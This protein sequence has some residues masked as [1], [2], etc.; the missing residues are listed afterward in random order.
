[1]TLDAIRLAPEERDSLAVLVRHLYIVD[2]GAA[3][4]AALAGESRQTISLTR[5]CDEVDGTARRDGRQIVAV[6]GKREC[7]VG[8]REDE[9]AVADRVTIEHVLTHGHR[10]LGVTGTDGSDRHSHRL[11]STIARVHRRRHALGERLRLLR[12]RCGVMFA[13][14]CLRPVYSGGRF[15]AN[16]S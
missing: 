8:K 5:R 7:A 15:T 4:D 2:P 3:A 13:L 1:M 10:Q 6:A 16:V 11:R 12:R 9:A 14:V